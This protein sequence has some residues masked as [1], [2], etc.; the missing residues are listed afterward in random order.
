MI[1]KW[2]PGINAFTRPN[3]EGAERVGLEEELLDLNALAGLVAWATVAPRHAARMPAVIQE[4]DLAAA[5]GAVRFM[6]NSGGRWGA[7]YAH[8]AAKPKH[9]LLAPDFRNA[10][11]IV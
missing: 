1:P 7:G 9:G 3:G 8:G 2:R 5:S 4:V 10:L 6:K 11:L